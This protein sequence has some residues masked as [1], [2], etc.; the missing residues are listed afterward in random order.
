[1]ISIHMNIDAVHRIWETCKK[2][3]FLSKVIFLLKKNQPKFVQK[4]CQIH[5]LDSG[6]RV[7]IAEFLDIYLIK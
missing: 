1:M 7:I 4:N 3:N 6:T 5:Y 2:T